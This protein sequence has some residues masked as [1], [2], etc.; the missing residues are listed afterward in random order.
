MLRQY[1]RSYK[2]LDGGE[3]TGFMQ[4]KT[5]D[6]ISDGVKQTIPLTTGNLISLQKFSPKLT[7]RPCE[8]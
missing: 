4:W 6:N 7:K 2:Y 3:L 5:G 8:P 1:W